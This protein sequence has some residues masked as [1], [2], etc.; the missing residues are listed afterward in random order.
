MTLCPPLVG[1]LRLAHPDMGWYGVEVLVF[2]APRS[3]GPPD[4]CLRHSGGSRPCECM[5]KRI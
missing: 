4:R 1:P 5:Y 2:Q 3:P